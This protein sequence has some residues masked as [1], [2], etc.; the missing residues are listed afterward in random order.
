[1]IETIE[2]AKA[3][4]GEGKTYADI[5]KVFNRE[6]AQWDGKKRTWTR[7]DIENLLSQGSPEGASGADGVSELSA[8]V[9]DADTTPECDTK[10]MAEGAAVTESTP[11]VAPA[12]DSDEVDA[13]TEGASQAVVGPASELPKRKW[14]DRKWLLVAI[15]SVAGV[16]VG[17][18]MAAPDRQA[19]K[20]EAARILADANGDASEMRSDARDDADEIAEGAKDEREELL[21][22]VEDEKAELLGSITIAEGELTEVK[23]SIRTAK[24]DLAST[25][26]TR[27]R[28][29]KEV[30]RLN[31]AI[32]S[33][34]SLS[35]QNA[36]AKARDYLEFSSFSCQGLIDQLSSDYGEQFSVSDATHAA[37]EV[38]LC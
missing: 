9:V 8:A 15:V 25:E 11:R 35:R 13:S 32:R 21:S 37:K 3:L 6:D 1:M 31:R 23:G 36:V 10:V 14:H 2:R 26:R 4:S 12:N 7:G 16:L 20:D 18:G 27:A 19:A 30:N 38:G 33:S 24:A 29:Q 17:A 5:A 34:T 22:G 28:K